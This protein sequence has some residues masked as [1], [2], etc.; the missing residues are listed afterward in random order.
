MNHPKNLIA[1]LDNELPE[2]EAARVGEHV[3]ACAECR[4]DVCRFAE[5]TASLAQ[6]HPRRRPTW[7]ALVP[8]A[9]AV[10]LMFVA[11]QPPPLAP[12]STTVMRI[13]I[14][15]E[16][17]LPPGFLPAGTQ[18]VADVDDSGTATSFDLLP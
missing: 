17:I 2:A 8:V 1:W 9:A 4:A 7:L 14:P 16:A 11:H 12:A 10:A 6:L 13:A 3:E 18:I 5:I 15:V